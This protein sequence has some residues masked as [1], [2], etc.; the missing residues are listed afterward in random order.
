MLTVILSVCVL[1]LVWLTLKG[2]KQ[3]RSSEHKLPPAMNGELPIIGHM[4]FFVY[5]V[6]NIYKFMKILSYECTKKGGVMIA[7]FGSELYYCITDPQDTLTA[8]NACLTRHYAY[9]FGEVW[10]G[11][12]LL[13]CSGETWRLR[14]KLLNPAFSLPVIH[15][16]LDVFNSQSKKLINDLDPFVG[17]GTFDHS[18]YLLKTSSDTLCIGTFGINPKEAAKFTEK[19]EKAL[20]ELINLIIKKF[21]RFWLQNALIYKLLGLKK[22]E[23]EL[24]K[25]LHAMSEKVLQEKLRAR[26]NKLIETPNNGTGYRPFLD[27]I[28]DLSKNGALTYKQIREETDSILFTGTESKSNQLTYI[29][30]LLGAHPDVQEKLYEE[31]VDILGADKDV[32]KDDLNKLVY[33]NAVIMESLRVLPT[34]PLML[35]SVDQDVKLKNYTMRAGSQCVIFPL[36]PYIG[37]TSG[38]ESDQFRPE[39]WLNADSKTQQEFA[40]FGLGKRAC[41]GRTYAIVMM[42]VVLAHFIRRYRVQADMSQLK[43]SVDLLMKPTAGHEIKIERRT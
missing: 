36:V 31:A 34:V 15:G 37:A 12:S 40:G 10:Q 6:T 27:L 1:C 17:K 16:F 18:S 30:L 25:T 11:N 26:K 43:L 41:L 4:H 19:Y 42:K 38:T 28:L 13:L 21:L 32:E 29:L 14:R 5:Y 39:R 9:N 3:A 2:S 33:T 7:K 35:R 24:V 22:K 23:D 8:A 20:S